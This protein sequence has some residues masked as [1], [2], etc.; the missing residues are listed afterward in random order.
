MTNPEY[1]GQDTILEMIKSLQEEEP[2][3][4]TWNEACMEVASQFKAEKLKESSLAAL[5]HRE[6]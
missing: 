6:F 4:Y 2:G 5:N 3:R 1:R